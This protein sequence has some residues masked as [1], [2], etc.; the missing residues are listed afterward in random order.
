M[1]HYTILLTV[2]LLG[3][4]GIFGQAMSIEESA[5]AQIAS[6]TEFLEQTVG[7]CPMMAVKNLAELGWSANLQNVTISEDVEFA[8]M[9][10]STATPV[11]Q[12]HGMGDFAN[13]PMG[14]V[15][16]AKQISKFLGGAYVLNV[17]IGKN[18]IADIMNGFLMNLDDQVDYFAK[19]V[20]GDENLKNGFNAI[21][22]S[23]GNLVIR[24]YIE[25]Y[26]NPPVFNF[27]SM[28]GP[29]S[30]VAGIPGCSVDK[31]MCK[32]FDQVLGSMAY[33]KIIQDHLCQA[34]YFRDPLKISEYLKG[35]KFLADV[36]NEKD[37]NADYVSNMEKL[38]SICLVKANKD[39]VVIPNDSEWFAYFEDGSYEKKWSFD[40]TP[41]YVQDLFGLKTLNEAGKVF[42]NT[43]D[44]D[45]L[46]FT[47]QQLLALVGIYFK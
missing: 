25:R 28:H 5:E 2:L 36:N 32:M 38:N 31:E 12:M 27:I 46:Q 24:G 40:Q 14:M 21:G 33:N 23:Q 16:L 20:Q 9:Q 39:T 43:T 17:Q 19:V 1:F 26:N 35:D 41:W 45:H 44:G 18:D 6:I 42:F 29:M 22:Y 37:V 8:F 34:N 7:D 15:P 10:D 3:T 47:Q 11:I 13:D 30:G 4:L